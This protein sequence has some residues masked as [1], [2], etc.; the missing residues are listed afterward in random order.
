LNQA[1]SAALDDTHDD[2]WLRCRLWLSCASRRYRV[3]PVVGEGNRSP[4]MRTLENI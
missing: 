2:D 3:K 1:Q 4:G